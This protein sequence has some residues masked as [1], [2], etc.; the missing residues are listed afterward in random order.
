MKDINTIL[1]GIEYKVRNLLNL[2]TEL[3]NEKADLISINKQL[4]E[5]NQ[6]QEKIINELKEQIKIVRI[7]KKIQTSKQGTELKLKINEMMREIDR[8]LSLLNN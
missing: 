8:C 6:E 5:K 4:S 2:Q 7:T 1:A 3:L